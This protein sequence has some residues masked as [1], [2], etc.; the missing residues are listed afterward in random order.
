[1]QREY[2]ITRQGR[3]YV[4]YAGLLDAA[5]RDGLASIRTT[6]VQAPTP[7]NGYVAICHAEVTTAR[8]TFGALGDADPENAPRQ[9][10]HSLVRLA[11]TRAKARALADAANIAM[12]AVEELADAPAD[13]SPTAAPP[14]SP[15]AR[16]VPLPEA[17]P[18]TERADADHPAAEPTAHGAPAAPPPRA[19]R[20]RVPIAPDAGPAQREGRRPTAVSAGA[21]GLPATAN[22]V[23]A[24][25]RLARALGRTIQTAGLTR[26]AASDLITQLSTDRFPPARREPHADQD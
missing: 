16:S 10:A 18:G 24:I 4:L 17:N 21:S 7:A 6:L 1:M 23:D 20:V 9:M 11:E 12:T 3:D 2:I 8:G 5:H 14:R 13:P 19:A 22:Q 25:T 15:A 26:I